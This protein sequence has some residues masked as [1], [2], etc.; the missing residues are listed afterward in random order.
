MITV[1]LAILPVF[2]LIF[3]G[4]FLFRTGLLNSEF[5]A[6]A[7]RLTYSLLFPALIVAT[8][9]KG[10]LT[11]GEVLPMVGAIDG[12]ILFMAL[13]ALALK[14]ML[15]LSGPELGSF[16]QAVVRMNTYLGLAVTMALFGA[17][18]L[19]K[20]AIAVAAIVPLVNVL[21]VTVLVRW[22]ERDGRVR[23]HLLGQLLRNPLV[24]A[25]A[26]GIGLNLSGVG[27]PPV[28]GPMLE[29]L[30]RSALALGLLA[31]GA[32]LDLGAVR[33][34]GALLGVSALL[35]LLVLPALTLLACLLLGV[36]GS[37]LGVAVLFNALPTAS[38]AYILARQLG[39]DHRLMAAMITGQTA[40]S[41]LTI[42]LVLGF[43]V[44]G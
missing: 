33:R 13:L 40:I 9:A 12:A 37:A 6:A 2:L 25:S 11:A 1:A 16:V 41:M 8:L 43:L 32:A 28:L 10:R 27:L 35:K 30:G 19:A 14:P 36:E 21:C 3:L 22:G 38:T 23:P 4:T 24:L 34:G 26:L 7:E 15:R 44:E 39:G 5:W 17:D 20:A 42:P 31:V 18:G 29:I